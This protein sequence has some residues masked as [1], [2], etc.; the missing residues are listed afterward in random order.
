MP[1]RGL[2]PASSSAGR[3]D[4]GKAIY[5]QLGDV[6]IEVAS[7][8]AQPEPAA[9]LRS[10]LRERLPGADARAAGTVS[11]EEGATQTA[12][13]DAAQYFNA[14]P[15]PTITTRRSSTVAS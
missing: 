4:V 1:A 5:Q 8:L 13:F 10:R 15:S 7:R 6:A 12:A 11:E 2:D 14:G 3:A 9:G